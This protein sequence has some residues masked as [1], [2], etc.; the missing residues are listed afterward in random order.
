MSREIV[1]TSLDMIERLIGFPTVSADSNLAL[2]DFARTYLEEHGIG[3]RLT[4]DDDRRK[5]NLFATIGPNCAGGVVLSGHTDVVPVAGQPWQTDPFRLHRSADRLYGRGTCDMKSFI[6]IALAMVPGFKTAG[7]RR[8]IHLAFS[9]DE[10]V[11]CIGAPRMLRDI[12]ENLPQPALA[13]IGEPTSMRLANRHKGSLAFRTILI[14]RDGHAS[15]PHRGVNA[16]VCAN[17]FITFLE[18]LATEFRTQSPLDEYFDP[19]YT[20]L[21]VGVISGGAAANIIARRC[22][23]VW[24]FRPLPGVDPAA[25]IQRVREFLEEDLLVRMRRVAPEASVELRPLYHVPP[26]VPEKASVADDLIQLLGDGR[27][28]VG[29]AFGTEAGQFQQAGIP[30]MV[31]GP[32]SIEQAHQPNEYI[33]MDQVEACVEFMSKLAAWGASTA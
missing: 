11:G 3:S 27:P 1:G 4:F 14:G 25:V 29:V 9:Y 6:A 31:F 7:L 16:I 30:A 5:A 15:A 18:R 2:I 23:V 13:V 22:E 20:T 8:P 28:A 10:E 24:D 32:G 26:L 21:N 19:P 12:V 17:E 33:A